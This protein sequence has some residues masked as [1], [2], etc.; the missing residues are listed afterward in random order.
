MNISRFNQDSYNDFELL[1]NEDLSLFRQEKYSKSELIYAQNIKFIILKSGQAKLSYI[2]GT[3]EFIINFINKG[4]I[5]LVDKDS[6]LEFMSDSLTMELN[7]CDI[8]ELFENEKFSMAMVNS[9][10]RTTI[11]TRQIVA[12]IVFGS[13][14]SRIVSFLHSLADEQH[15]MVRDK[16]VVQ[17]PFSIATLS[18]LLGAQRQSVSTIFNKLI[19]SGK[20]IKYGKSSY[21][22]S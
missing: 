6:V 3:N 17:I 10:I 2:S 8:K 1:S 16:K 13:L 18:N 20:L 7:L 19:K 11:M 4:S 9:L 15:M 22:I 5:V 14:E 12:D 21:I